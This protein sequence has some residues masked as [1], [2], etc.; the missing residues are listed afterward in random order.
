VAVISFICYLIS[1]QLVKAKMN[2]LAKYVSRSSVNDP[3]PSSKEIFIGYLAHVGLCCLYTTISIGIVQYPR[4]LRKII[5]EIQSPTHCNILLILK[6]ILVL[7][8]LD[9]VCL[10]QLDI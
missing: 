1:Q 4:D 10:K 3:E 7:M 8:L 2:L 5:R 9:L 6:D